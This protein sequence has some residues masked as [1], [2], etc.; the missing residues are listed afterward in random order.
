VTL[1]SAC[2]FRI[3][4]KAG[5]D[6][7]EEPVKHFENSGRRAKM[8]Q[9]LEPFYLG[10]DGEVLPE[11]DEESES[12]M[13]RGVLR[14]AGAT[15][16]WQLGNVDLDKV[17][18][19]YSGHRVMIVLASIDES[20]EAE[21]SPHTCST[22]GFPLDDLGECLRCQWYSVAR[23]KQLREDL[24]QEIDRIVEQSWKYSD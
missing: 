6:L 11:G 21:H 2:A 8:M 10:E 3:E 18:A 5:Y 14:C 19:P 12:E 22:C 15:G 24:F 16:H 23:A 9:D 17:L 1:S 4:W 20:P 13:L 7:F